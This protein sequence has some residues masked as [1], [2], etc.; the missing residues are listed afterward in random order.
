MY[1]KSAVEENRLAEILEDCVMNGENPKQ[2]N[3]I[4]SLARRCLRLKG[5]EIPTTKEVAMD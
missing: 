5:E 2:I 4:A 3:E 1:F